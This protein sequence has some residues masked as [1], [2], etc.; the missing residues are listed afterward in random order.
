MINVDRILGARL[1]ARIGHKGESGS[2]NWPLFDSVIGPSSGPSC[3]PFRCPS[4]V[5]IVQVC[6][7]LAM[8]PTFS[9]NHNAIRRQFARRVQRIT[10]ADFLLREVER[11]MF[12]RL[13][14]IKIM[15]QQL[16]DLGCGLGYGLDE[17]QRRFPKAR[18]IGIDA[19]LPMLQGQALRRR[20][21]DRLARLRTRFEQL[22]EAV[23]LR[24][25]VQ[26][27]QLW[28]PLPSVPLAVAADASRL[29]FAV[30]TIDLIWSNLCWHW[31]ADPL[32][33]LAEWHRLIKP[34][35]LV[36]FTSFGVDTFTELAQLGWP[37]PLFP[38]MHDIGDALSK[39]GFA[40]PVMDA[41]RLTLNYQDTDKLILELSALGGN[42]R[43]DRPAGLKGRASGQRWRQILSK[44]RERQG[45]QVA[46]T[47]EVIYGHAW[48]PTPKRL[49][50]GLAPVNWIPRSPANPPLSGSQGHRYNNRVEPS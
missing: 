10:Q 47:V 24:Q 44:Q 7:E 42:A 1:A 37:L 39:V 17:L 25:V 43:D 38:D 30:S 46:I 35:G 11:R 6:L 45:G 23:Q 8:K 16:L 49:P 9:L 2:T 12:D 22:R 31:L 21:A 50:K 18:A 13:D 41:E 26:L 14:L 48:C 29:P 5:C 34:G 4:V 19:A 15:P 27:R 32:S 40:D 20:G 33:S 36:M 28:R 3:R